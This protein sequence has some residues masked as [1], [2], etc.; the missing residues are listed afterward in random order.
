MSREHPIHVGRKR[1]KT[2]A[3]TESV[4]LVTKQTDQTEH[5]RDWTH[6]RP[7]RVHETRSREH[8]ASKQRVQ[9]YRLRMRH[10]CA[11]TVVRLNRELSLDTHRGRER[12]EANMWLQL[13]DTTTRQSRTQSGGAT[14]AKAKPSPQEYEQ[15]KRRRQSSMWRQSMIL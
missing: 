4:T 7:H 9:S 2:H 10:C 14:T 6:F 1:K 8:I 11:V 3:W 15:S 5:P 12:A 13:P